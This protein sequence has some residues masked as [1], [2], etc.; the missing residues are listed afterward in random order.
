MESFSF[1]LPVSDRG[2]DSRSN[3]FRT[4]SLGGAATPK[5]LHLDPPSDAAGTTLAEVPFSPLLAE[6]LSG[7]NFI[8][9]FD[10]LL[11]SATGGGI[12]FFTVQTMF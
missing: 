3:A 1:F 7:L 2:E 4:A 12:S 5:G 11:G 10:A 9:N 8:S 6:S